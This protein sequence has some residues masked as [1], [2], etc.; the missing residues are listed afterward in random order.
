MVEGDLLVYTLPGTECDE[1]CTIEVKADRGDAKSFT[2]FNSNKMAFS[3]TPQAGNGGVF[4]IEVTLVSKGVPDISVR[5]TFFLTVV[6]TVS[7]EVEGDSRVRNK[8]PIIIEE[9]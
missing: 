8:K 6:G 7:E 2:T 3:F 9:I 1:V 4:A 5:S